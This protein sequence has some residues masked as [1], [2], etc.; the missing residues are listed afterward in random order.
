M[1][2]AGV[3]AVFDLPEHQL[4]LPA[5]PASAGAARRF[6]GNALDSYGFHDGTVTETALLLTSELVTNALLYTAGTIG[7]A[8]GLA[9]DCVRVSVGDRSPVLPRRRAVGPDAT[10]GRGLRLVDAL[11]EDWGV[12]HVLGDGKAVWF[13]LRGSG[14]PP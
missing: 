2:A 3:A 4:E 6:V 13:L 7:V 9:G 5:Y 1:P 10:S 8:V 12:D 14:G 11:A